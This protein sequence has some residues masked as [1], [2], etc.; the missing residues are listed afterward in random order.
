MRIIVGPSRVLTGKWRW[1]VVDGETGE[2]I[3]TGTLHDTPK[4]ARIAAQAFR[5]RVY[6]APIE[7]GT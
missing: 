1:D 5:N 6:M 2:V 4:E 3:V 7:M